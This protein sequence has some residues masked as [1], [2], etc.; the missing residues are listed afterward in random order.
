[1]FYPASFNASFVAA[2]CQA[3]YGLTPATTW[4]AA[5]YGPSLLGAAAS[6][7]IFSNGGYDPWSA[8]G[9]NASIPAT[10]MQAVFIPEGAHH[11]DLF[12]A[13]PADPASVVAARATE[14]AAIKT[15]VQDWYAA[16]VQAQQQ[17][18]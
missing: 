5:T 11:L 7:I 14:L 9:V 3:K 17:E 15:W 16:Q 18:L 13:N 4:I 12:F 1:M 10:N 6:N 8:G 2:H